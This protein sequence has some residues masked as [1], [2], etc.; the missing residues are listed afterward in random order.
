[1]LYINKISEVTYEVFHGSNTSLV[2]PKDT[3]VLIKQFEKAVNDSKST[4]ARCI[5]G[6]LLCLR[7][8]FQDT[9]TLI[10]KQQTDGIDESE[11]Y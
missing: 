9:N 2:L 5:F 1:M 8:K 7:P 4:E 6:R 3:L 11:H 10:V